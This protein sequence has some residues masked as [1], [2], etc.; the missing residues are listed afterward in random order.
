M[1]VVSESE[2]ESMGLVPL[3]CHAVKSRVSVV[4]CAKTGLPYMAVPATDLHTLNC[5]PSH[6]LQKAFAFGEDNG[7]AGR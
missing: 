2:S 1:R 7:V 6:T 5:V 4:F 3:S